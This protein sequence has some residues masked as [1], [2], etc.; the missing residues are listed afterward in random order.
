M[1]SLNRSAITVLGTERFL[2]WV[3]KVRP[4]LNGWN[5]DSLNH[6]PNV[7]L[8]DG[9]DQNCWGDCFE[10]YHNEIFMKEVG[11]YVRQGE[12]WPEL[13]LDV[14]RLWFTYKYHEYLYDLA[15][16]KLEVFDE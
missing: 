16:E 14:Y 10:K 13:T 15:T 6:H 2:T 11:E 9:E 3:K 1:K 8:V 7:Y 12:E 5:L 4:E